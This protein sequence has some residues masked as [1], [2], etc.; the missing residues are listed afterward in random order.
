[1]IRKRYRLLLGVVGLLSLLT[2]LAFLV[3][4]REKPKD[5]GPAGLMDVREGMTV[6]R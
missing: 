1:M 2:I 3:A 6:L 4:P 5:L